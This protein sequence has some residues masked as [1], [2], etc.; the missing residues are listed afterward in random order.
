MKA[1]LAAGAI[2]IA[3]QFVRFDRLGVIR[4]GSRPGSALQSE[5]SVPLAV[6][7]TL[8]R[9]CYDC[10]SDHPR[11]P[12]YAQVAPI[13]WWIHRDVDQ[14]QRRLNFSD[15]TDYASD[16]GTE[17]NKLDQIQ[18]LVANGAMPPWHY[19]LTHRGAQLT[20]ADRETI[21]R[22]IAAEKSAHAASNANKTERGTQ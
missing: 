2:L 15:W 10:H 7:N 14:G 19:R 5:T 20:A 9:S 4:T 17:D 1:T 11:W 3:A 22:W 12:W 13:S 6:V 8:R 16:P 18:T 21:F